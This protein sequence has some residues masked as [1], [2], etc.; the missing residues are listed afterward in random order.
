VEEAYTFLKAL[1]GFGPVTALEPELSPELQQVLRSPYA[2]MRMG[3]VR[4]LGHLLHED[5]DLAPLARQTLEGLVQDGSPEV[6]QAAQE[7]L[8]GPVRARREERRPGL[9]TTVWGAIGLTSLSWGLLV[10]LGLQIYGVPGYVVWGLALGEMLSG[11]AGGGALWLAHRSPC[12]PPVVL[13]SA[14]AVVVLA[15]GR[16]LS[17]GL[18]TGLFLVSGGGELGWYLC[19]GSSLAGG[20]MLTGL[21][22]QHLYQHLPT[23]YVVFL[24]SGWLVGGVL[25]SVLL[26]VTTYIPPGAGWVFVGAGVWGSG[27]AA[28]WGLLA[29]GLRR[30]GQANG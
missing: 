22:I 3:A 12:A 23:R 7:A 17:E 9:G 24:A 13:G 2:D 16:A 5:T 1:P 19:L 26:C 10:A 20:G 14:G 15:I 27:W 29:L 6:A 25:S 30:G 21:A 28:G 4:T 11:L 8:Q 18:G